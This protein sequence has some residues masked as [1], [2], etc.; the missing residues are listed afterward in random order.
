MSL[1]KTLKYFLRSYL[2]IP[3]EVYNFQIE[4]IINTYYIYYN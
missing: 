2:L 3:Y 1:N 4:N